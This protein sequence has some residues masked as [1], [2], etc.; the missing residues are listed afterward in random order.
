MPTGSKQQAENLLQGGAELLDTT[1]G[2]DVL[3]PDPE[4]IPAAVLHLVSV[5]T[6]V[7]FRTRNVLQ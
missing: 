1:A 2:Q 5:L 6:D 3:T 4:F 7:T